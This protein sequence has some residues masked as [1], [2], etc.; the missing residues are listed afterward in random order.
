MQGPG[1]IPFVS[2]LKMMGL[3]FIYLFHIAIISIITSFLAF[4]MFDS[5]FLEYLNFI[6]AG[7][8]LGICSVALN[9]ELIRVKVKEEEQFRQSLRS[10]RIAYCIVISFTIIVSVLLGKYRMEE[11][12]ENE[13]FTVGA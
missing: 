4:Y 6:V 13:Y 3:M 5:E 10:M 11:Q 1:H 9:Y 12:L 7:V 8:L 2:I